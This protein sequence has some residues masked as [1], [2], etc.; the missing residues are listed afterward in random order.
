[1]RKVRHEWPGARTSLG[2]NPLTTLS[3]DGGANMKLHEDTPAGT[4]SGPSI[5]IGTFCRAL[6]APAL[7]LEFL[8]SSNDAGAAQAVVEFV[9]AI[10]NSDPIDPPSG[11]DSTS[12][13]N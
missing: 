7:V 11:V 6:L 3:C 9:D 2:Y 10:A 8:L 5:D 13:W 1:L 4:A 12:S